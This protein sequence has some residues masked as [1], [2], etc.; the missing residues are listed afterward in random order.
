MCCL[1]KTAF[2]SMSAFY[3]AGVPKGD[4]GLWQY[5]GSISPFRLIDIL[6]CGLSLPFIAAGDG[7]I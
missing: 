3:F 1:L 7:R 5:G 6:L 2:S 4:G